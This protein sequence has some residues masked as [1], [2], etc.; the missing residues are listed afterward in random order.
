MTTIWLIKEVASVVLIFALMA[1]AA[2]LL[3]SFF[4]CGAPPTCYTT[5]GLALV[6]S[7][8]CDGASWQT[9]RAL[10]ALSTV[11]EFESRDLEHELVHED[12]PFSIHVDPDEVGPRRGGFIRCRNEEIS[13]FVRNG[14]WC[15]NAITHELVHYFI[16]CGKDASHFQWTER[17]IYR[18]IDTAQ[19]RCAIDTSL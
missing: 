4:S 14:D 12:D 10:D 19:R 3:L 6:G 18:A 9:A 17:G 15:K 1:A 7:E 2:L 16:G 13:V 5:H 11:P 8:D